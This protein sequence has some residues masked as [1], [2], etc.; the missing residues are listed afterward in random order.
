MANTAGP[1]PKPT[2]ME[3]FVLETE[4]AVIGLLLRNPGKVRDM[5]EQVDERNFA[6]D[7]HQSIISGMKWL[8]SQGK[9]VTPF[10]LPPVLG[11]DRKVT[12]TVT[13]SQYIQNLLTRSMMT[14]AGMPLDQLLQTIRDARIR[15]DFRDV[16]VGL[17][18]AA[19]DGGSDLQAAF[20]MAA[21]QIDDIICTG[22]D[23]R[24][25]SLDAKALGDLV[26]DH[27][28]AGEQTWPTTGLTDLDQYLGGWPR[29]QLSILAGRPGMGKS[30]AATSFLLRA[31]KAGHNCLFLSLEMTGEQL[32]SRML[33]DLS[34][35]QGSAIYYDDIQHH[36]LDE[37]QRER[38]RTASQQL[39]GMPIEVVDQRGLKL[40]DIQAKAR[41]RAATLDRKGERLDVLFVDHIGLVH[42]SERYA[43]NRV[44]ELAEITDTLATL[45]KELDCAVVGLCQLNRGVEKLENKR[46]G[47]SDLRDS[48]AIEED[49]ST[50][51]FVFRPAYY[52]E[53]TREDDPNKEKERLHKLDDCRHLL[54]FVIA[55]NRNGRVGVVKTWVE[56]GAN[57]IRNLSFG[58]G[59]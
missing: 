25:R 27:M 26:M 59:R 21:E 38:L 6:E 52:L 47:L 23:K 50:V 42:A 15:R 20:H 22:I 10:S 43:G 33:T 4:Q 39:K 14:T 34:F 54:E 56:I 5:L 55:K 1:V 3:E 32:G 18:D 46:P 12:D 2:A 51:T 7:A 53:N 41:R 31:A 57:A 44:R 58:G 37:K 35:I 19:L 49:A 28:E 13:Y 40:T 45:A 17:S 16:A 30:A 48:G 8:I 9:P 11:P 29:G 36:R 24:R